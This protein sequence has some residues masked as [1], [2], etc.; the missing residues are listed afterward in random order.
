MAFDGFINYAITSELNNELIGGKIN[1]IH[2]PNK[3]E[4]ILSVYA[5]TTKYNLLI[6]INSN[7]CRYH[8]TNDVK[9]NPASPLTFCMLLRKH[10]IG[11]KIKK[12]YTNGLDRLTTIEF[13]TYNEMGDLIVKKLQIELMGNIVM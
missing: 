1:K 5:K 11:A 8:L 13:E 7:N 4:L 10:L 2:Q 3:D 6:C 12:I 9:P